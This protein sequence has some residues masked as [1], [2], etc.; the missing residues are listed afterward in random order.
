LET[1]QCLGTV[2]IYALARE[3]G[4]DYSNIHPD[5][6]ALLDLELVACTSEGVYV[7]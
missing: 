1:L 6:T 2:S 5:I 4:R 3:L 7:P